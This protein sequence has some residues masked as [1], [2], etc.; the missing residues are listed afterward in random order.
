MS[1]L[2]S[3]PN[4]LST[5][6]RLSVAKERLERLKDHLSFALAARE[7]NVQ[8]LSARIRMQIP[9]SRAANC[10]NTLLISQLRHE[11][12]CLTAMWD[13][14]GTDL[15]S[16]PALLMLLNDAKVEKEIVARAE[17]QYGHSADNSDISAYIDQRRKE[18]KQRSMGSLK[19]L[20]ILAGTFPKNARFK[21]VI[22]FR[23]ETIAHTLSKANSKISINNIPKT[24]GFWDITMKCVS[25]LDYLISNKSMDWNGTE[26]IHRRNA[27]LFWKSVKF[28]LKNE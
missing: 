15:N 17:A 16:I 2:K 27:H 21:K 1:K 25:L 24:K 18:E 19:E 20:K 23:N 22:D 12:I 8:L 5:L 4:D 10:Y 9:K 14:A 26:K 7:S 28:N 3:W 6:Q 11:V 13:S